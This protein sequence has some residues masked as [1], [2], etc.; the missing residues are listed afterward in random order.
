MYCI[1][2][3]SHMMIAVSDYCSYPLSMIPLVKK[4]EL[5]IQK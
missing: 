2:K 4:G 3:T 5:M 1:V